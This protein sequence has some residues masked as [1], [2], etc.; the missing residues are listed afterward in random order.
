MY[1]T[2]TVHTSGWLIAAVHGAFASLPEIDQFAENTP[3]AGSY[4]PLRNYGRDERVSSVMIELRHKVY[5]TDP[6]APTARPKSRT[7]KSRSGRTVSRSAGYAPR[8]AARTAVRGDEESA[9][10]AGFRKLA[11]YILGGNEEKPKIA[12]TAPVSQ[13]RSADNSWIISFYMPSQWTMSAL[14]TPDNQEVELVEVPDETIAARRFTGS[15]SATAV[16]TRAAELLGA[17]ENTEW[18]PVG[19]PVACFYDPSWSLPFRRRNEVVV[20]VATC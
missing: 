2:D 16:A 19:E 14:P 17:L 5:L 12:M 6:A 10:D 13:A 11:E 1:R 4:V 15:R 18:V 7:M 3:Y 20:P 8:R 9:R